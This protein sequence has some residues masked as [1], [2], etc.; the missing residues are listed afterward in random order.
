MGCAADIAREFSLTPQGVYDEKLALL[1]QRLMENGCFLP[2]FSR[3]IPDFCLNA[4]LDA[5]DVLRDGCDRNNHTYGEDDHSALLPLG[6]AVTYTFPTPTAVENIHLA[7]DSDL[8]RD[9]LPGDH[10]EK[11]HSMRANRTEESP[12]MHMPTTLVKS[13]RVTAVTESGEEILLAETERNLLACVN[14]PVT[15]RFASVSFTPTEVWCAPEAEEVR[16]FSFD[17]R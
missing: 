3:T 5:S 11:R 16:V 2:R 10:C 1:Q 7:F 12:T 15:G 6:K 17:L 8:N 13:Y 9:T 4:D 14:I